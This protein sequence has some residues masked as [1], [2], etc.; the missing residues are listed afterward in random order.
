MRCGKLDAKCVLRVCARYKINVP[1]EMVETAR[2][3]GSISYVNFIDK[4]REHGGA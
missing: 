4:V 3:K 2:Q 1:A